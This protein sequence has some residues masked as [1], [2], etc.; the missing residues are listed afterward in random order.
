MGTTSLKL[1]DELKQRVAASAERRGVSM[2]AFMVDAIKAATESSEM[3]ASFLAEAD[4]SRVQAH[5]TGLAYDAEDV[6]AWLR[7]RMAGKQL[8][9]PKP[10]PW[11]D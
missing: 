4:A 1:P 9:P 7:D 3:R 5:R 10:R 2:H 8:P 11:R 6:H